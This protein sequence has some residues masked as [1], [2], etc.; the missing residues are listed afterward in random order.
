MDFAD[1]ENGVD[2]LD[3]MGGIQTNVMYGKYS[4]VATFPALPDLATATLADAAV[5][6]A[7]GL[8]M[9][10][11]TQM[12]EVYTTQDSAG[13]TFEDQGELDGKSI[14]GTLEIF[15]PGLKAEILALWRATNNGNMFFIAP[16]NNGDYYLI[17]NSLFPA[18]KS[19][20]T[21]QTG[22]TTAERKGATLMYSAPSVCPIKLTLTQLDKDRLLAPAV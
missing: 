22:K 19:G 4:D 9:N 8:V 10:T 2:G 17:G 11:G 7:A 18:K 12:F 15:H 1:I 20:G 14:T 21:G 16:D 6:D 5:I 3:N 13:V